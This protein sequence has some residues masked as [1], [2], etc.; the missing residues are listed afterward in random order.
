MNKNAV[1]IYLAMIGQ[2]DKY[3]ITAR[4]FET[5]D[6]INLW[7]TKEELLEKLPQWEAEGYT[8]WSSI[9]ELE[10]G[11]KTIKGV[12]RYCTLWFDIDSKRKDKTQPATTEEVLEAR[13]RANKLRAFLQEHF[14]AKGFIALSGNGIQLFFPFECAEV[15]KEKREQLNKN[16]QAFAKTVS[17]I[18]EAEIDHTYD[19]RRVTAIIGLKNQ[20][21]PTNPLDTGW[22]KELYDPNEGKDMNCALQQ[23]E[24]ARKQN[25]FLRDII[26]NYDTLSETLGLETHK[27]PETQS[28]TPLPDADFTP[29]AKAR[30]DELR[31]KNPKL[32]ALL[33]KNICIDK[34][35]NTLKQPCTYRYPSRSEAEESLLV[36]LTCYGFTKSEI[37]YIMEHESQIGKWKDRKDKYRDLSYEKA[38]KYCV[39]HKTQLLAEQ[40]TTTQTGHFNEITRADFLFENGHLYEIIETPLLTIKIGEKKI[41]FVTEGK[42]FKTKLSFDL[43]RLG[44]ELEKANATPE[45][46]GYFKRVIQEGIEREFIITKLK[47]DTLPK[48]ASMIADLFLE[49]FHFATIEETDEILMYSNGVYKMRAETLIQKEIENVVPPET[50]TENLIKEVLGHIRRS[51]YEK[52]EKFNADPYLLNLKNGILNIHTFEFKP[53]TPEVLSTM[54]IPVEYN[55]NAKCEL[56]ERVIQEDLY[57][58]DIETL[59]E[60]FGYA[61][62]LDNRAQKMFVFLGSGSN[63]K[64]LILHVLETM[65]GKENVANISPQTLVTNEFALSE[66]KDKLLNIYADLPNIPMQSVGRIKGLVSGD[67][68]TADKKYKDMFTF[69][70]RAKF[71]F[72][73]NQLPKVYDDTIAFYRRLVIINFPKTFDETQADPHLFEKLTTPEALSG[74]FNW[75]LEGLRRLIQNNF[76]FSYHKS[77]DEL[78][79]L[80]TK[81]SDPIK[82][83]VEEEIVEDPEAWI[84]KQELY[85]AYVEYVTS[86]KLQSPVSQNTFFKSLPK[87]VRATTEHKN[88]KGQRIWVFTG[89]RLKNEREKEEETENETLPF[90][91]Q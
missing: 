45:E 59:Q 87:Y 70:N 4:N 37:Y 24:D 18:A 3:F 17:K 29:E 20:K 58:E 12:K 57:P 78:K 36:L 82:A 2:R 51:T 15:P 34:E 32:D 50:I 73:A 23:I 83:F 89:I 7:L 11:D 30:L 75:S 48:F 1:E 42:A 76:R 64:S 13:E 77:V 28:V 25:T 85:R 66:L 79:E 39:Q 67:P 65:L 63:G 53:H 88:V 43:N 61:L 44:K 9:N 35:P 60:A 71:F 5:G 33:N 16:L 38:V 26:I 69:I 10:A 84:P 40:Q 56:W 54:Q 80:Y 31:K 6:V 91:T 68:I 62:F 72:S 46:I 52:L 8:V 49:N 74:I 41:T 86:H 90:E 81:A 14:H 47:G 19:T 27:T 55:P 22:E 21:I